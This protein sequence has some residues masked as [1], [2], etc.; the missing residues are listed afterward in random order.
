MKL[1]PDLV[2]DILIEM[3]K[4]APESPPL[5]EIRSY[6]ITFDART[7]EEISEHVRLM[8]EG[9]LIQALRQPEQGGMFWSPIR[10]TWH[11]HQYLASVQPERVYAKTKEIASKVFGSVT[12]ET[13]KTAVPLALQALLKSQGLAP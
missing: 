8:Q 4:Q 13:I 9:G 5:N 7:K 12:I 10:M 3:E 2:R 1:D 6:G 11:G